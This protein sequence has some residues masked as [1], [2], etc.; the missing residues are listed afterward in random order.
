MF[1]IQSFTCEGLREHLVTDCAAPTFAYF[2]SSDRAGASVQ[3]AELT[4]NGWT[5]RNPDQ[6]GTRYA[7]QPLKPFTTYTATLTVT[8]DSGETD[9]ARLTFETGRM[10]TPWQG[11]WITD[12][13]YVFK[14]KKVSP[15]PMV[16]RKGAAASGRNRAGEAVRHGNGHLRAEHRRAEGRRT[17][18]RARFHV[19]CASADVPNV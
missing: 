12:G 2:V 1:Q 5:I 6:C 10:D 11:K 13:A 9:T 17:V 15:V 19:L 8:S 4:V 7:G 16:F 3:S 14:E 18:F